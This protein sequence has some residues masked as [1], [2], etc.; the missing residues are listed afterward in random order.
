MDTVYNVDGIFSF[1]NDMPT[2]DEVLNLI[3]QIDINKSS[4]VD[5]INAKFCK[6]AMLS[7]QMLFVLSCVNL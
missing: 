3:R 6:V 7:I 2:I 4:G 5:K 1:E